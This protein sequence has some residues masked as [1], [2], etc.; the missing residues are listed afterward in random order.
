MSLFDDLL[1]RAVLPP[2]PRNRR[3]EAKRRRCRECGVRTAY[4]MTRCAACAHALEGNAL[5][6]PSRGS[7]P[8]ECWCHGTTVWVPQQLLRAGLTRSCGLAGCEPSAVAA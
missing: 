2:L 1:E 3:S 5:S 6:I 4:G 7:L 8:A